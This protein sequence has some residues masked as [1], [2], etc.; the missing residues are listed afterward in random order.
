MENRERHLDRLERN[1]SVSLV[2]HRDPDVDV[3][4]RDLGFYERFS[5]G[6]GP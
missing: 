3:E 2:N 6:G 5:T 4:R 1:A